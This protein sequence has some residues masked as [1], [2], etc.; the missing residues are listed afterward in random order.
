[1]CQHLVTFM[2]HVLLVMFG[3][4]IS[5]QMKPIL[6]DDADSLVTQMG[7]NIKIKDAATASCV[8]IWPSIGTTVESIIHSV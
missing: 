6:S 4:K 2:F 8:Y 5:K 7:P 3:Y 1:M